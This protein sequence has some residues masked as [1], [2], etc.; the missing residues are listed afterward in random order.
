MKGAELVAGK[1]GVKREIKY[2]DII[3]VPDIYGWIREGGFFLTTGYS[4]KDDVSALKKIV[5]HLNQNNSAALC[6]KKERYIN[7]I[8]N[9]IIKIA[10][11]LDF[12]IMELDK[13]VS[14][15]DILLPLTSK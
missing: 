2:V 10:N 6:I 5:N 12:P 15:V 1:M 11:N 9:E 7:Q 14:Y 8:S 3:E 4:I 13:E